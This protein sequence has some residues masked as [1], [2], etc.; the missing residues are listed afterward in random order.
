M[1][2]YFTHYRKEEEAPLSINDTKG[3]V[4]LVLVK[5]DSFFIIPIF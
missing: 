3:F 1:T 2:E 4:R 5:F